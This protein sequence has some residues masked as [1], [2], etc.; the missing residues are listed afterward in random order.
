MITTLDSARDRTKAATRIVSE[1]YAVQ[2]KHLLEFLHAT[3]SESD[4]AADLASTCA[5][6]D[7]SEVLSFGFDLS[8]RDDLLSIWLGEVC[9][10]KL[11]SKIV[12]CREHTHGWKSR[13]TRQLTE[14]CYF[15][16]ALR[17]FKAISSQP[18]RTIPQS[19][20]DWADSPPG[21]AAFCEEQ[22]AAGLKRERAKRLD[23]EASGLGQL[24]IQIQDGIENGRGNE[25][26]GGKP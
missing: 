12:E 6:R 21:F 11:P 17:D 26:P 25:L 4:R 20:D 15:S 14:F 24:C 5:W 10:A 8:E 7:V 16:S 2:A 1:L 9:D 22:I 19:D 23:W 3:P 18:T 13:F